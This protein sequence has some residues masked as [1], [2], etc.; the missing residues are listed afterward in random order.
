M[1]VTEGIIKM[2]ATVPQEDMF[3]IV[4]IALGLAIMLI[5]PWKRDED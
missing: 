4:F 5:P 2:F 1:T 3:Y